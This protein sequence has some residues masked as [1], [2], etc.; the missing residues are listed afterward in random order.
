M[1][2]TNGTATAHPP[3]PVADHSAA[4]NKFLR[5]AQRGWSRAASSGERTAHRLATALHQIGDDMAL[6]DAGTLEGFLKLARIAA[7]PWPTDE[8][9]HQIFSAIEAAGKKP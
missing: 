7:G 6:L 2:K 9:K 3:A 1:E 8:S 4:I 5:T